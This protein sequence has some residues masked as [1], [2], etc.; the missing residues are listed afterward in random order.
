MC[1]HQSSAKRADRTEE[2]G[3]E[4]VKRDESGKENEKQRTGLCDRGAEFQGLSQQ[5]E[6]LELS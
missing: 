4:C 1:L 2:A 3:E 5:W 6:A